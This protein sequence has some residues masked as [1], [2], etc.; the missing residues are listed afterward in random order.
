MAPRVDDTPPPYDTLVFDC[1]STLARIEG[2]EEL[3]GA[4]R[5]EIEEMTA[6]AMDGE[7]ALEEVY[8][9][10]LEL[11]RPTRAQVERVGRAYVAQAAPR[12][13][14][15]ITALRAL[16]KRVAIVSG[17][18]LPAVRVLAQAL[19]VAAADVHAVDV[20]FD[21]EG[22]YAG[23]DA[24][25]P[26][27]RSG[28]KVALLARIAAAPAA[29]RVALVGDGVTDLEAARHAARFVAFGGFV[30]R[31]AVFAR[32]AVACDVPD[33]A[34]LAPLLLAPG[35]LAALAARGGHVALLRAA[36]PHLPLRQHRG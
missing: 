15:L 16:D 36:A 34:A 7:I 14:E 31:A 6:R 17:G 2:V 30:R 5:A 32:A 9:R 21:A 4:R 35:E 8:G 33:F 10:R 1:D 27:A 22:G 24:G 11:V 3:A 23:F 18:L 19:G 29:G 20:W 25:S 26:L 28:G 13:R 12:A